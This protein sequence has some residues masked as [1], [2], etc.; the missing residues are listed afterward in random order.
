M[1]IDYAPWSLRYLENVCSGIQREEGKKVRG[2][3]YMSFNMQSASQPR[4]G[5]V[6]SSAYSNNSTSLFGRIN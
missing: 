6:V 2:A 4:D 1:A 3:R 5:L